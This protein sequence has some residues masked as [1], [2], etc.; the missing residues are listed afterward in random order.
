MDLF[1][2]KMTDLRA[3]DC[4]ALKVVPCGSLFSL[5]KCCKVTHKIM[6]VPTQNPQDQN[7]E[8]R[9]FLWVSYVRYRKFRSWG[10]PVQHAKNKALRLL[11]LLSQIYHT[12]FSLWQEVS[13]LHLQTE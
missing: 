4:S 10:D 3:C 2:D 11:R 12:L 13:S 8:E 5:T 9:A 1:V 7:Q 6:E